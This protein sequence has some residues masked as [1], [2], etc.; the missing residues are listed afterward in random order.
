[1]ISGHLPFPNLMASSTVLIRVMSGERPEMLPAESPD[2]RAYAP[3][4][5][6][7]QLCWNKFANNRPRSLEVVQMLQKIEKAGRQE[8]V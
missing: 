5:R 8:H 6:V 7:A 3:M 1:M 4:W 2:G